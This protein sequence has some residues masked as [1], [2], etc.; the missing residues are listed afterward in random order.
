MQKVRPQSQPLAP[1][2]SAPESLAVP[3]AAAAPAAAARCWSC[4][5]SPHRGRY[6]AP[7]RRHPVPEN[8]PDDRHQAQ[9]SYMFSP[10]RKSGGGGALATG[11]LILPKPPPA[12]HLRSLPNPLCRRSRPCR[13]LSGA[14]RCDPAAP[15]ACSNRRNPNTIRIRRRLPGRSGLV[16]PQGAVEPALS[17]RIRCTLYCSTFLIFLLA[18]SRS[19]F[20]TRSS[21]TLLPL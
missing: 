4:C 10:C 7:G 16:Q 1:A 6:R 5:A 11:R 9:S 18:N 17:S 15:T 12:V 14:L 20:K 3:T 8:P 13:G 2:A 19:C 21:V